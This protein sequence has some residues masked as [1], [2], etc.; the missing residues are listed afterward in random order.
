M[1]NVKIIVKNES[2]RAQ[3]FLIFNEKPTYSESVGRAWTTVWGRSPGTAGRHGTTRF[4]IEEHYYA[5]CGMTQKA[6]QT[7]LIVSTSDCDKVRLG[8]RQEKGSLEA[9]EI[10]EGG[11][12][13]DKGKRGDLDKDGA[14]GIDTAAYGFTEYQ[15]VFCGL[16]MKSPTPGQEEEVM[17]VSVWR[18]D[19]NQRYKITPKRIYY[20]SAGKFIPGRVV[21]FAQLGSVVTIDFTGRKE[22]VAMVTF[23]S[24]LEFLPVRYSFDN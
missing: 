21:D 6:L 12:V 1:A 20:V 23:D 10:Q 18:P 24:G 17:P 8:T 9:L 3:Q 13:F 22:T 5:V 2:D 16:G 14:F 19:S 15:N 11:I 7:D 4:S